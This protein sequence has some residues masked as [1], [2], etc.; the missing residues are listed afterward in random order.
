[1]YGKN[2]DDQVMRIAAVS[3]QTGVATSAL[4]YYEEVGLLAPSARSESGYRL[5]DCSALGR[6]AFIQR[7][8]ALGL[9]L[10]EIKRLLEEPQAGESELANNRA[11]L[12]HTIAHK[13]ADTRNRI[14]EL[15]TLRGELEALQARLGSAGS[16]ECGRIGDCGCW[17]PTQEEVQDMAN[18]A[19]SCC[20]CTCP[21]DGTCTCCGCATTAK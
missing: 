14:A 5:Y 21:N 12:R 18:D 11:R 20:D 3:R 7:A 1:V 19:C 15:E 16:V 10:A 2:V 6:I 13:L 9:S 4:R 8:K 17:L